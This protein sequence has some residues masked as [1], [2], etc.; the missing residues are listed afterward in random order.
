ML[1][2]GNQQVDRRARGRRVLRWLAP[3]LA[4]LPALVFVSPAAASGPCGPP[5][6]QLGS[7]LTAGG[8]LVVEVAVWS[9]S[10]ASASAVTDSAGNH[11][12]ELLHFTASDKTEMSVWS[13]PVTAG[14]GTKPTITA[15]PTAKADVGLAALEYSGLSTASGAT[16][17][18]QSAHATGTTSAAATV[19][20]GATP[21]S[22]AA[23]ELALGFYADSGFG[24]TLT[25]G[26][27]WT[28]RANVSKA[29]DIELLGEDQILAG[30]ATPSA[31]AATGANTA[32]LMATVVLKHG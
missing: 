29:G 28:S 23:G 3:A 32:W 7:N 21:A 5:V 10:G 24:D 26:T 14:A 15:T 31:T 6:T 16:V 18:D 8:R 19:A 2:A 1:V 20:S 13:A 9:N 12:T 17:L 11:Y 30:G 25:A 4:C 27:G 22:N